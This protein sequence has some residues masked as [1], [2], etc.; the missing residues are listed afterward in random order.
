MQIWRLW[1]MSSWT[2]LKKSF[3]SILEA[4]ISQT[5]WQNHLK[6]CTLPL[7]LVMYKILW[8]KSLLLM[9]PCH[10]ASTFTGMSP[11]SSMWRWTSP[12]AFKHWNFKIKDPLKTI[13]YTT[14]RL[15][16]TRLHTI[17]LQ[18]SATENAYSSQNSEFI[19]RTAQQCLTV[20]IEDCP[21]P[22]LKLH[23]LSSSIQFL[24]SSPISAST[25]GSIG[26]GAWRIM[27][28]LHRFTVPFAYFLKKFLVGRITTLGVSSEK[29][30]PWSECGGPCKKLVC[31]PH[32]H[33]QYNDTP[34]LN[35][36]SFRRPARIKSPCVCPHWTNRIMCMLTWS[37]LS[38]EWNYSYNLACIS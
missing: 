20:I 21:I 6:F 15:F 24:A 36:V 27:D 9:S 18:R 1:A 4:M 3:I 34:V 16:H 7:L 12:T 2:L 32:L 35:I 26:I 22:K 13:T 37:P 31:T 30:S 14:S 11:S 5:K 17:Q 29:R 33:W 25:H 19:F 23:L 38:A 10:L 8:L 28:D